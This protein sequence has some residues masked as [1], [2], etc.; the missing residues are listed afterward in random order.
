MTHMIPRGARAED[1]ELEGPSGRGFDYGAP[2]L[3]F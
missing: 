1:E 2:F 3:V